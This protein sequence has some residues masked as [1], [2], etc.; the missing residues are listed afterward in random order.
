MQA[1][2]VRA[3]F[4][5]TWLRT[6]RPR[7][8]HRRLWPSARVGRN[9][10]GSK[11]SRYVGLLFLVRDDILKFLVIEPHA[12]RTGQFHRTLGTEFDKKAAYI[13]LLAIV[14]DQTFNF[15]LTEDLFDFV[16]RVDL[17]S[18]GSHLEIQAL[19]YLQPLCDEMDRFGIEKKGQRAGGRS[20]CI[21]DYGDI[22]AFEKIGIAIHTITDAPS[23]K[24]FFPRYP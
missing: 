11:N 17:H 2:Y 21:A 19:G 1:Q 20:R 5:H 15:F 9:I 4:W 3:V 16:S 10:A 13:Q 14:K 8:L 24:F 6:V 7:S 12:Q 18:R 22:F 23:Q